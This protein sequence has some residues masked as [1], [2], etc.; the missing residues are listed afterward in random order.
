ML[1][2]T[3]ASPIDAR[4]VGEQ[5]YRREPKLIRKGV[6][7]PM[8]PQISIKNGGLPPEVSCGYFDATAELVRLT[9][10]W[11][12]S[13]LAGPIAKATRNA[14][15]ELRILTLRS[16]VRSGQEPNAIWNASG[17]PCF[18]QIGHARLLRL[19]V[20]CGSTSGKKTSSL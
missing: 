10:D 4:W 14:K 8:P 13:Q 11:N 16:P 12:V 17:Q 2:G 1:R 5:A 3:G 18:C 15:A 20:Q 9:R 19:P 7:L 6:M